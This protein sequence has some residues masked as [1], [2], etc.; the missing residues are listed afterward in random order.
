VVEPAPNPA[1]RRVLEKLDQTTKSLNNERKRSG[2]LR[3]K[4]DEERAKTRT[5]DARSVQHE[6]RPSC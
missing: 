1:L 5:A 2:I 3:A 4:L 6:P